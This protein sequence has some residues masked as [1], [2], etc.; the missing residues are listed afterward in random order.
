MR[1][2]PI[3]NKPEW[4]YSGNE[5]SWDSY[6]GFWYG[7]A[8]LL[9]RCPQTG[10]LIRPVFKENLSYLEWQDWKPSAKWPPMVMP[11]NYLAKAVAWKLGIGSKPSGLGQSTLGAAVNAWVAVVKTKKT[12]CYRINLGWMHMVAVEK[13]GLAWPKRI[14]NDF[15]DAT[16]GTDI[17]TIDHWCGRKDG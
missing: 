15:C 1:V 14:K 13:L 12:G 11:L 3:S 2:H 9:E 7:I 8:H 5:A 16:K 6:T 17:P 4:D 10:D